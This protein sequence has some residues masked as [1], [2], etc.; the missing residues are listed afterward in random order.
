MSAIHGTSGTG[1]TDDTGAANSGSAHERVVE[2][3][4]VRRAIHG[5]SMAHQ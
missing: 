2:V 1:G 5:Q 4:D 3:V